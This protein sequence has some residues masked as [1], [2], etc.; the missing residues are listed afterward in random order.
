MRPLPFTNA[1]A[2]V[3]FWVIFV[4]FCVAEVV[5]QLRSRRNR[6]GTAVDRRSLL[7]VVVCG[8]VAFN[9]AFRLPVWVPAA[10]IGGPRWPVFVAGLVVMGAGIGLRQW[11][12]A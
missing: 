9:V 3:L 7:L 12:I 10:A 6:S 5:T 1:A 11:A 4:G 8:A 2:A